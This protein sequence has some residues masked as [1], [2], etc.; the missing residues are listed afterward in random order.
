[1]SPDSLTAAVSKPA[2]WTGRVLSSI[3]V[4]LLLLDS[5]MKFMKPQPVIDAFARLGIPLALDVAIG[6]VLLICVA[7]YAIPQTSVLGAI[8]LTGYLGGAIM[9]HLRVGDPLFSH[10]LFSSYLGIIVW[11][12][13]WLREPRLRALTPF[14]T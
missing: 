4:L 3:I 8:L 9:S 6:V 14:R 12:A 10:A 13:L 1:M 11:L 5:V 7:L 2:L